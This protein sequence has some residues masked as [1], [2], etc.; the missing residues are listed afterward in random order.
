MYNRLFLRC[1]YTLD[2]AECNESVG[3]FPTCDRADWLPSV[4]T[5]ARDVAISPFPDGPTG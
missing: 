3:C 2:L 4:Y 5:G 1:A